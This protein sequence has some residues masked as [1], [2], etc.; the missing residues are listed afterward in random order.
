MGAVSSPPAAAAPPGAGEPPARAPLSHARARGPRDRTWAF[1]LPAYGAIV[2]V[3]GIP[4]VYSLW[5]SFHQW[6]LAT[7]KKGV[8]FVGLDNY[9]SVLADDGFWHSLQVTLTFTLAALAIEMVLGTALAVL[10]DQEFRGRRGIRILLL[11]PMFVTNVVIGLIWRILLSYDFG[12]VNWFLSLLGLP[13]V[14]WLGDP[15]LALWSLVIVDV[16]NTTAFVTLLV[17]AGLQGVPDE[18]RQAARVDGASSWQVFRHVTLPLLRPVLFVAIVWRTIDLF[19]IFDVVF[20][21][22]GGG[23]Y[24]ATETISLYA[25]NQGFASFNLGLASAISYLII[26]GL[27]VLLAIEARLFGRRST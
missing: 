19:R 4:V 2:A 12:V 15:G 8:P 23:P 22:T 21:L 18:P 1:L 9:A 7:F 25:Y 10:L 17:L 24:N 16:W 11:L 13:K 20:S 3:V 5:L 27:A 14:A 26:I 6:K